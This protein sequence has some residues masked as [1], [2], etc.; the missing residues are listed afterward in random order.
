ML[1]GHLIEEVLQVVTCTNT[2]IV[3]ILNVNSPE[4]ITNLGPLTCV[5]CYTRLLQKNVA[6]RLKV[7]LP[8]IYL[9]CT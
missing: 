7:F 9:Y 8:E 4:K 6:T 1:G 5:M 3:L 2:A